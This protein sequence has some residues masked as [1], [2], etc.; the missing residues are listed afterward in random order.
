QFLHLFSSAEY[1]VA[2]SGSCITMAKH[3]YGDLSLPP[4]LH[5]TWVALRDRM[6]E[7]SQFLEKVLKIDRWRGRFSGKMT[8]H[9]SCH[10]L[11]ELGISEYPRQLLRSIEDLELL[12][13][14]RSDTCCGFG[15]TFSVKYA[16]ISGAMMEQKARWIQESGAEIVVATDSSCL[17][18]MEGYF[19]KHNIPIR[20]MHLVEVL[21]KAIQP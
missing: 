2:P 10:G 3:M 1:V 14:E 20:T 15:G 11:R 5:K 12:E 19:Q 17:M 6:Y 16:D 9:D 21:W 7:F 18:H 8:Y 13:M 4:E